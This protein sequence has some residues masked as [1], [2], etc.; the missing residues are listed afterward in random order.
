MDKPIRGNWIWIVPA[1]PFLLTVI[2]IVGLFVLGRIPVG[3]T[4]EFALAAIALTWLFAV[5]VGSVMLLV[6]AILL[7]TRRLSFKQP[8]VI[9]SVLLAFLDVSI[10]IGLVWLIVHAMRQVHWWP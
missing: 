2:L 3:D 8:R 1:L 4:E 6:L 7:I 10:P 9:I 5:L